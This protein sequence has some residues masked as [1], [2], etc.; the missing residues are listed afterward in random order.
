MIFLF[1]WVAGAVITIMF[2][3]SSDNFEYPENSVFSE[4]AY[5]IAYALVNFLMWPAYW[6]LQIRNYW[7]IDTDNR[8]PYLSHTFYS[9]T[10][11]GNIPDTWDRWR[12]IQGTIRA[13][14]MDG[15]FTVETSEDI[16]RC[17][18]GYMAIDSR[19]YPY[20]IAA[21]EFERIYR[22][23]MNSDDEDA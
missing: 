5:Y 17:E 19:G 1:I 4:T 6:A 2:M 20:P 23:I 9:K 10:N 18:D 12:R 11:L 14:R 7:L 16:V 22:P 15:P 13:I 8:N 21:E 3:A